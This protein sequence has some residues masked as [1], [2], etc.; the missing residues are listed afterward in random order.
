MKYGVSQFD[1][2]NSVDMG[3]FQGREAA[4]AARQCFIEARGALSDGD[5]VTLY[6]VSPNGARVT[7]ERARNVVFVSLGTLH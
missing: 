3:S 7:L 4:G 6:S 1:G 2:K 5:I